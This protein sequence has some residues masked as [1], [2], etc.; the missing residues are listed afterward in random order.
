MGKTFSKDNH[1]SGE[2]NI[3]ITEH[4]EQNTDSHSAH[5]IK[6]WIIIFLLIVQMLLTAY[7]ILKRK[8]KRQGFEHAKQ[9]STLNVQAV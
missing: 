8:W 3:E 7:K 2:T 9:L 1:Q 6:L 4:L 5:E